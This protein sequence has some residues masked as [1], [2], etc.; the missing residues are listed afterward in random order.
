MTIDHY[1][2]GVHSNIPV[3]C[4]K[5]FTDEWDSRNFNAG[6]RDSNPSAELC[7][8]PKMLEKPIKL[9]TFINVQLNA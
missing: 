8:L 5:F 2:F 4:V 3:C 7:T 1:A 9:R 6:D